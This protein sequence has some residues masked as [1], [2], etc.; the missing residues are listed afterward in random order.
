M[1]KLLKFIFWYN[2]QTNTQ[3]KIASCKVVLA[4]IHKQPNGSGQR[5]QKQTHL[6][7]ISKD[8]IYDK[9]QTHLSEERNIQIQ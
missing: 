1:G 7:L 6:Y 9:E 3:S 5:T 4:E 2:T 8:L